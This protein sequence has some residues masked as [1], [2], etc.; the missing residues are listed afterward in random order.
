MVDLS[1]P[2]WERQIQSVEEG[3]S[4]LPATPPHAMLVFNNAGVQQSR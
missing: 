3:L 4:E 2:A 1:H